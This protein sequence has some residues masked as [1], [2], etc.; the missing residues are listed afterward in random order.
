MQVLPGDDY[1]LLAA[2]ILRDIAADSLQAL[3]SGASDVTE[4]AVWGVI[5]EALALLDAGL[6]ESKHNSQFRL[7][8]LQ[9]Y[10]WIGAAL[11]ATDAYN[12]LRPKHMQIDTLAYIILPMFERCGGHFVAQQI[13]DE[14]N[15]FHKQSQRDIGDATRQAYVKSSYSKVGVSFDDVVATAALSFKMLAHPFPSGFGSFA[16]MIAAFDVLVSCLPC[17]CLSSGRSA[18]S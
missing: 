17:R 3:Q 10:Y 9:M 1:I 8:Q 13:A 15:K 2:H 7:V 5:I 11:A 18:P 6:K 16:S 4:L 12:G 14:C